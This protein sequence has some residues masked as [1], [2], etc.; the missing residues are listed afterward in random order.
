MLIIGAGPCGMRAAIECQLLGVKVVIYILF[1]F[2]Y[3]KKYGQSFICACYMQLLII[4]LYMNQ[5][6]L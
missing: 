6:H 4:F 5:V 2:N 3:Y 1:L